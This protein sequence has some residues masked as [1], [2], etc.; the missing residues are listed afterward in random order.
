M[1]PNTDE[2]ALTASLA[3]GFAEAQLRGF[4]PK[5]E[6]IPNATEDD[7]ETT[8]DL[9][10]GAGMLVVF[11]AAARTLRAQLR[12]LNTQERYKAGPVEM[13]TQRA[14]SLLKDELAFINGR[15]D[16]LI[17]DAE[18]AA[19]AS[20]SARVYDNYLARGGGATG[21]YGAFFAHEWRR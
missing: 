8:Q 5:L 2:E 15:I 7:W 16:E 20:L 11:F 19:R 21:S 3:D 6:L 13:E 18:A 17:K 9:S 14:A 10:L 1:F 4:F 12:A